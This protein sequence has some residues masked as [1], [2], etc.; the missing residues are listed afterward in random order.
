MESYIGHLHFINCHFLL[1]F[2]EFW[3]GAHMPRKDSSGKRSFCPSK[4]VPSN[5]ASQGAGCLSQAKPCRAFLCP[6]EISNQRQ[7]APFFCVGA[8]GA[9]SHRR[10]Q[11]RVSA[12]HTEPVGGNQVDVGESQEVG[13]EDTSAVMVRG[14]GG[15]PAL[16]L[17]MRPFQ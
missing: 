9:V 6:L 11:R 3:G 7:Q 10:C 1:Y 5:P 14:A 8:E 4:H 13:R 12:V 17:A 16:L 15:S 2:L